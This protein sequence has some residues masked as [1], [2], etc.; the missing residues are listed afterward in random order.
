MEN[1]TIAD[2]QGL[3]DCGICF[4]THTDLAGK[5]IWQCRDG[6]SYCQECFFT[7]RGRSGVCPTCK[8]NI[9]RPQ[10]LTRNRLFEQMVGVQKSACCLCSAMIRNDG[11]RMHMTE[12]CSMRIVS[13]PSVLLGCT[14]QGPFSECQAHSRDECECRIVYCSE[15]GCGWSGCVRDL[16]GHAVDCI[17]RLKK[18]NADCQAM[19][20]ELNATVCDLRKNWRACMEKSDVLEHQLSNSTTE[21]ARAYKQVADMRKKIESK[22]EYHSKEVEDIKKQMLS[23]YEAR[24]KEVEDSQ[25]SV[26]EVED[27]R[28]EMQS[29]DEAHSKE[30]EDHRRRSEE[31]EAAIKSLNGLLIERIKSNRDANDDAHW[32][33]RIRLHVEKHILAEEL[34]VLDEPAC[35]ESGLPA[36]ILEKAAEKQIVNLEVDE[37]FRVLTHAAAKVLSELPDSER[38]DMLASHALKR[39][40]PTQQYNVVVNSSCIE[41]QCSL[42]ILAADKL[43]L[44]RELDAADRDMKKKDVRLEEFASRLGNGRSCLEELKHRQD[45][46]D[47]ARALE[48]QCE[49]LKRDLSRRTQDYA[50][51]RDKYQDAKTTITNYEC[52]IR[53]MKKEKAEL[54]LRIKFES[55]QAKRRMDQYFTTNDELE[56]LRVRARAAGV[57]C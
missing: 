55:D 44:L 24:L 4:R 35:P 20:V 11:M 3:L 51:V 18:E 26:D 23:K 54:E 42:S 33:E 9:K 36:H 41:K 38:S 2:V 30:L 14:W 43:V 29:R 53:K 46:E 56:K 13:C 28:K 34:Q 16:E 40:T 31:S 19:I 25:K 1:D 12:D 10:N 48:N 45:E 32:K 7:E 17:V 15:Q 22:D 21:V 5:N 6:H 49:R 27:M 8:V 39:M 50:G 57:Q 47:K 52:E 37:H